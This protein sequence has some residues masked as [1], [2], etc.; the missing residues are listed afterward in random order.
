[1]QRVYKNYKNNLTIDS[2]FKEYYKTKNSE[3]YCPQ[4]Q[5]AHLME[6]QEKL[7]KPPKILAILLDRGRGK[8]FKEKFI[9][10]SEILDLTQYIDKRNNQEEDYLYYLVAVSTHSG[11]SSASGHYTACCLADDKDYYYFSDTFVKKIKLSEIYENEPYLLFYRRTEKNM[12]NNN[13]NNQSKIIKYND[14]N[15]L[16][17]NIDCIS[18]KDNIKQYFDFL[19]KNNINNC[20]KYAI[21]YYDN[22]NKDSQVLKLIING[23]KNTPYENGNFVFKLD[24]NQNYEEYLTDITTLETPIYHLNF[25]NKTLLF[26][27]KYDKSINLLQNLHT[28]FNFL[29]NLL[30]KPDKVLIVR[31]MLNRFKEQK[32]EKTYKTKALEFTNKYAKQKD[33]LHF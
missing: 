29:Y 14:S 23:P 10:N 5:K 30:E 4:C 11:S 18:P 16:N 32:D 26:K 31:F 22:N 7:Y 17:K 12:E 24:F 3:Y 28:Y 2:C 25:E 20:D 21:D 9:F 13:D 6:S 27:Y 33:T 8:T 19:L 15:I 1:L